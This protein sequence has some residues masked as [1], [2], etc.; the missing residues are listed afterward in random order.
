MSARRYLIA[1]LSSDSL[2]GIATLQDVARAEQLVDAHRTEVLREAKGEVVAWL[3]K[4][5][6]EYRSTGSAQHALQA[7]VIGV[8]ASKV[9]RGAI[10]LF[11]GVEEK[12]TATPAATATPNFFQPGHVYT[13]THHG[14]CIEFHVQHIDT[15]PGGDQR[16]AF[17]W[18][19]DDRSTW[20]PADSDDMDGWSD[21][22]EGG[23]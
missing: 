3:A 2:G 21:V 6:R 12:A 16:V 7:D 8:L 1:A 23:A 10:R 11:L 18:R 20:E 22:T 4:K 17:G 9:D 19:A 5:E 15:D 13:R 14:H